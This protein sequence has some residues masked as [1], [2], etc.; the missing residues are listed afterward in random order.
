MIVKGLVIKEYIV[1]ESDKY[2]TLFSR[3]LGQIQVSAK[4][5]KKYV[6]GLSAGTQLFV[7]GEFKIIKRQDKYKLLSA[8]IIMSFYKLREDLI[9]LSYAN[10]IIEFLLK[11]TNENDKQE[12]LLVLAL[13][14]LNTLTK[15]RLN[16]KIVRTIFD[17]KALQCLGLMPQVNNCVVCGKNL[18]TLIKNE[19]YYFDIGNGGYNC[20]ANNH[21]K[22]KGSSI[23]L[24][25]YIYKLPIK[26]LYSFKADYKIFKE[27]D[28]LMYKYRTYYIEYNFNSLE[29]IKTL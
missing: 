10:Y 22:L 3:E 8:D 25:K 11:V 4:F 1:G 16:C 7:Y 19:T 29:Y 9:A 6:S 12:E 27:L 21:L 23:D 14:T 26:H 20:C 5:A 2:I 24:I 15:S 18:D 17:L 13:Y 28:F